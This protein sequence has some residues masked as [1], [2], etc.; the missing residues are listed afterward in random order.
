[1]RPT[2]DVGPVATGDFIGLGR[3]GIKS[4]ATTPAEAAIGLLDALVAEDHELVTVIE[5]DGA[6]AAVTRQI[7]EWL[8]EHHPDVEAEIHHGGQPLYPYLFGVE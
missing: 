2:S 1:M 5:G 4:V 3:D 7:T 8:D 6:S